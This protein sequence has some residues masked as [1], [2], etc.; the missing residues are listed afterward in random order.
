LSYDL[1]GR[2]DRVRTEDLVELRV[3]HDLNKWHPEVFPL[4]ESILEAQGADIAAVKA[5]P[6]TSENNDAPL[7]F[8]R[9][10]D[11]WELVMLMTVKSLLEGVGFRFYIK[12]DYTQ[13]LFGLGQMG[14]YNFINGPPTLMVE[15]S[16]LDDARELLKLLL[17]EANTSPVNQKTT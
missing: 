9:T 1:C 5:Q 13:D 7:E 3:N 12:N 8:V 11:L 4:V 15:A 17:G 10:L 6:S 16:R 14:G 2:F